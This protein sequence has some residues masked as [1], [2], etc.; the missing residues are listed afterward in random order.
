VSEIVRTPY[1][2]GMC[3]VCRTGCSRRTPD[4]RWHNCFGRGE[5]RCADD[6]G[7]PHVVDVVID[8]FRYSRVVHDIMVSFVLVGEGGKVI[9]QQEF[10][11]GGGCLWSEPLDG[12]PAHVLHVN[13]KPYTYL[14][15]ATQEEIDAYLA[16][17]EAAE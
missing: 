8:D 1:Q 6:D 14:T 3:T 15:E 7:M 2:H 5:C 9:A 17:L 4:D 10:P 13:A 12:D 11:A 16:E